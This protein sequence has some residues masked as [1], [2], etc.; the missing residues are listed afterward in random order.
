MDLEEYK[1]QIREASNER[2]KK[3]NKR[4]KGSYKCE[5]CDKNYS[6]SNTFRIHKKSK[7]HLKK[8]QILNTPTEPTTPITPAI[9]D[10]IERSLLL[11]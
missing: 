8:L 4:M 3:H 10:R 7:I 2:V 5:I 1:K 6:N 11:S 9:I